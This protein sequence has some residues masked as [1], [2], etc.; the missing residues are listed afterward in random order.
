MTQTL[1]PP[2]TKKFIDNQ[3]YMHRK[4]VSVLANWLRQIERSKRI[5][6]K[7]GCMAW[8]RNQGIHTE[9]KFHENNSPL[10]FEHPPKV[11]GRILFVPDIVV[12][13][14][15]YPKYI[16]EVVHKNPPSNDKLFEILKFFNG[17]DIEVLTINAYY[18]MAH[19]KKPK[20]INF[21]KAA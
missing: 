4:A 9:L 11:A 12:F 8:R 15:G 2:A 10:Y 5:S 14:Q 19:T 1:T 13:H 17:Y 3:S 7:F 21:S 20:T 18:I 16:I 6:C